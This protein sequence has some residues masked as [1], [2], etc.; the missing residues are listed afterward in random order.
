MR[1]MK[2]DSNDM[3]ILRVLTGDGRASLRDIA[4]RT[5][6]STPT[7]SLR[8]SRMIK[9]GLIKG[10]APIIDPLATRKVL[11]IVKLKVPARLID[12][13]AGRLAKLDEVSGVFTTTGEANLSVR[14]M[15]DDVGGLQKFVT[16][17]LV[18]R[19]NVELVSSDIVTRVIKD[20]QAAILRPEVALRL[21]CDYCPGEVNSERPYNV[22]V[23][24]TYHYFCC[25]TCRRSFM[26]ERGRRVKKTAARLAQEE[27]LRT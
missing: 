4:V 21:K 23:G 25:R 13:L 27:A 3:S 12:T 17:R 11:A 1:L 5:D 19:P 6:L 9:G 20:V 10:F 16:E 26:A 15:A 2:L 18:G 8:L 7:V 14:V 24:S 22:R